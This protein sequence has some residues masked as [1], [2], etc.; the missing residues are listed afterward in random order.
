MLSWH[1]LPDLI[2]HTSLVEWSWLVEE[3]KTIAVDGWRFQP[4]YGKF[5]TLGSVG[6]KIN[7]RRFPSCL[8]D[9]LLHWLP[10]AHWPV[11]PVERWPAGVVAVW[12]TAAVWRP[13]W[14]TWEGL[15]QT[16]WSIELF[17]ESIWVLWFEIQTLLQLKSLSCRSN[18][19]DGTSWWFIGLD[20]L[21]INTVFKLK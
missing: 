7:F 16:L 5:G 4:G 21:V 9:L 20:Y 14:S 13:E 17:N 8:S 18:N 2:L 19:V 12:E 3:A 1:F 6:I 11:T 15:C 10:V